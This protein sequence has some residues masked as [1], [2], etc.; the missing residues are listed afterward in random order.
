M[1]QVSEQV[2]L[3][4]RGPLIGVAALQLPPYQGEAL[5][6]PADNVEAV[7]HMAG[8]GEILRDG[9]LIGA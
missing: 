4:C 6:E 2:R 5:S 7:Q 3:V 8:I 9:S 1:K